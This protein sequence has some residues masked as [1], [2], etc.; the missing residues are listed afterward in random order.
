MIYT[1]IGIIILILVLILL[2][3]L[4]IPFHISFYIKKGEKN[5]RGNFKIS[6]LKIR[7]IQRAIPSEEKEKKEKKG[8]S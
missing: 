1:I 4:L 2:A 5:I 3:I 8:F 6:W 7:L